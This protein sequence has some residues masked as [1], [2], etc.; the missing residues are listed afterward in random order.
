MS[1][2]GNPAADRASKGPLAI[3]WDVGGWNCD[4]NPNSRDALVVLDS[5]GAII[6]TP[7]RGNLRH[8]IESAATTRDWVDDLLGKCRIDAPGNT[9]RVTMA[10]DTPLGFPADFVRLIAERSRT[11]SPLDVSGSNPYLFRHT[12]RRL[13]ERG[14]SPLSS[15]KDMIGSQATK[16]IHA[17]GKFAPVQE[18]CGVWTD[19]ASFRAIETYPSACRASGALDGLLPREPLGHGDIDDAHVCA[20]V[21]LLF[22]TDR[23]ELDG[24]TD[25]VPMSEGWIWAPALPERPRPAGVA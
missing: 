22:D 2:S 16:A 9:V 24:P 4:R 14:L 5:S 1:L 20:L 6:G 15:I 19:G 25:D 23:S 21:A 10:I 3:G 8:S 18:S 7:W 17:L 13:F 11:G 12:E